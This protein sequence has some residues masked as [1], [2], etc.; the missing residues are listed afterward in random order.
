M[1]PTR[2]RPEIKGHKLLGLPD[3]LILQ[4]LSF[5]SIEAILNVRKVGSK[6]P[7]FVHPYLLFSMTMYRLAL[8][9][10]P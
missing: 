1:D 6:T 4:I 5:T 3:E 8:A 7:Y 10:V 2:P 9:C